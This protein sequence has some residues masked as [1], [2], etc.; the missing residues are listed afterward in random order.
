MDGS[1]NS[2]LIINLMTHFTPLRSEA[3]AR[4]TGKVMQGQRCSQHSETPTS[5]EA[6]H[7]YSGPVAFFTN[8]GPAL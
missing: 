7:E 6:E 4:R 8:G 2:N 3:L 5:D 1:R